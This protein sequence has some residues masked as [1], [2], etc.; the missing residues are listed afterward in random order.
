MTET[1]KEA[2]RTIEIENRARARCYRRYSRLT[3]YV[4]LPEEYRRQFMFKCLQIEV[5]RLKTAL[6]DKEAVKAR[7]KPEEL[8]RDPKLTDQ[9]L[10]DPW[11]D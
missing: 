9:A 5:E 1:D 4:D 7:Q 2:Q 3:K 6:K 10:R 8:F 11:S